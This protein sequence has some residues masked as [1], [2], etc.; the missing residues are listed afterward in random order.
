MNR[1]MEDS[2]AS[3]WTD[4]LVANGW[5]GN[6]VEVLRG[7]GQA[8]GYLGKDKEMNLSFDGVDVDLGMGIDE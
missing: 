2:W 4:G 3:G 5:V 6:W 8:G 7:D 1:H